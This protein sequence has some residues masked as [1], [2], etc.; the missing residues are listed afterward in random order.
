M[1][2]TMQLPDEMVQSINDSFRSM[3]LFEKLSNIQCELK[4]P[5]NQYNKFGNF[6]YRNCEDILESAK[7][8][9]NKYRSTLTISDEI[10]QVDQRYY[11]KAVAELHD[12]DSDK[13]VVNIAYAREEESKKGMD[14]SQVTG[15]TSSYARKYAL[16]GLF[17]IDDTKDSDSNESASLQ[18]KDKS[19]QV[20]K[21]SSRTS[22]LLKI[23]EA[24]KI[25]GSIGINLND[26]AVDK[27]I[28]ERN[29]GKSIPAE[30][31]DSELIMYEKLLNAL[32][33]GK[34]KKN[35]ANSQI[36]S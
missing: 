6:N 31:S 36:Q 15:A 28:A 16:N 9:C 30:M 26:P 4:A 3:S 11:V 34:R 10:E 2:K 23:G 17:N 24:K 32:I 12:W 1:A 18:E 33:D 27:F 8:L 19:E 5:K 14:A 21:S 7:P 29:N 25:A 35:E 13:S 22:I 20:S